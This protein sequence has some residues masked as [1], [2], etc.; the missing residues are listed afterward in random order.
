MK[1]REFHP[2]VP[3]LS[4]GIILLLAVYSYLE[5]TREQ[6][7]SLQQSGLILFLVGLFWGLGL[8]ISVRDRRGLFVKIF[9]PVAMIAIACLQVAMYRVG[10]KLELQLRL[11]W[12]LMLS[13]LFFYSGIYFGKVGGHLETPGSDESSL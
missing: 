13:G 11:A 7:Y 8:W 4:A 12:S 10:A 2:F 1:K 6:P 3:V 9:L 5:K